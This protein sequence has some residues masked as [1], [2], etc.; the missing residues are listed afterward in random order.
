MSIAITDR[1]PLPLRYPAPVAPVIRPRPSHGDTRR[2]GREG[3]FADYWMG[4]KA[5]QETAT[6]TPLSD[7]GYPLLP[8][9][10]SPQGR[11]EWLI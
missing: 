8:G 3:G 10:G 7:M 4:N 9:E 2:G 1:T 11:D 5:G 6:P